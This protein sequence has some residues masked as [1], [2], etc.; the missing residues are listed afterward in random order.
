MAQMLENA[1][2]GFETVHNRH[3]DVEHYDLV[4]VARHAAHN[5]QRLQTVLCLVHLEVLLQL[6][7]VCKKQKLIVVYEEQSWLF[8]FILI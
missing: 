8:A 3:V 4:V 2:A 6:L 5:L 1:F 7:F